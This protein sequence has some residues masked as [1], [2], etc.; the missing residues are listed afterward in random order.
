MSQAESQA[1]VCPGIESGVRRAARRVALLCWTGVWLAL[2]PLMDQ[3]DSTATAAPSF[4]LNG[5]DLNIDVDA[6]WLPTAPGGYFPIRIRATNFGPERTFSFAFH[7]ND[8]S[9]TSAARLVRLEQNATR[10][11]TLLVPMIGDGHLAGELRVEYQGATL[12]GMSNFVTFPTVEVPSR[13]GL[14]LLAPTVVDAAPFESAASNYQWNAG[15]GAPPVYHHHYHASPSA[16]NHIVIAPETAPESWLGWT[17]AD[18]VAVEWSVWGRL[19]KEQREGLITWA[20]AGGNLILH[21]VGG[22]PREVADLNREL[23]STESDWIE[24]DASLIQAVVTHARARAIAMRTSGGMAT[25]PMMP[26]ATKFAAPPLVTP[27]P[28]VGGTPAAEGEVAPA[29]PDPAIDSELGW[30]TVSQ[31]EKEGKAFSYQKQGFGTITAFP[32]NPFPGVP[33]DWLWYLST[34]GEQ[35]V[36]WYERNALSTRHE[37][38]EFLNFHVPGIQR[39]PVYAFMILITL[40]TVLI[41]PVNYTLMKRRR[42]LFLLV[43]TIP[44]IAAVTS[45]S[46]VAYSVVAYGF[47]TKTRLRSV[48][49]IDQPRKMSITSGRFSMYSGLSPAQ[50]KFEPETALYPLWRDDAPFRKGRVDWTDGQMLSGGFLRSRTLTQFVSVTPRIERQRLDCTPQPNETLKVDNGFTRELVDVLVTDDRGQLYSVERIPAGGSALATRVKPDSS[51]VALKRRV[52]LHPFAMPENYNAN[53]YSSY[54]YRYG[55]A[56]TSGMSH[57]R[58]QNSQHERLL[59][60]LSSVPPDLPP[61]TYFAACESNPG[62]D[63]G[64]SSSQTRDELHVLHGKY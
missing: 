4:Q 5:H 47:D 44:L 37:T 14:V 33:I 23:S 42:Q 10:T 3:A 21:G 50:M 12:K 25:P 56:W 7:P 57:V 8:G 16:E 11:F 26:P 39:I 19:R 59:Q 24:A 18:I 60:K 1:A 41:G 34:L 49:F 63:I 52:D 29:V 31:W 54:R 27:T 61:R 15:S 35:R 22:K 20:R 38:D 46:L 30:T 62:L 51:V 53:A 58:Y 32:G 36:R 48:T 55:G 45:V 2:A 6:K 13:I 40:F 28:P 43:L 64:L 9:Q 17:S